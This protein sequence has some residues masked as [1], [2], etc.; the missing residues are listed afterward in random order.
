M[1]KTS[2][3]PA[4]AAPGVGASEGVEDL[5]AI[6]RQAKKARRTVDSAIDAAAEKRLE[7]EIE[8]LYESEQWEEIGALYFNVRYGTTGFKE[9]LLEPAQKKRI[10]ASLALM[11]R[12]L[13]KLDPKWMALLVF[14]VNFGT[15]LGEKEALWYLEQKRE[16]ERAKGN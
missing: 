1:A 4:V 10:G 13:I 16:R 5:E 7:A 2:A 11:M 15:V 6:R 14:T 8:Q 12:I 9:F 3:D